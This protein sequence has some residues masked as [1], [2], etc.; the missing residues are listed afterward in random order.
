MN[1]DLKESFESG[2]ARSCKQSNLLSKAFHSFFRITSNLIEM[3]SVYFNTSL[4]GYYQDELGSSNCFDFF[5][6][7]KVASGEVPLTHKAF[8]LKQFHF[9]PK[10]LIESSEVSW[11]ILV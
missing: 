7:R 9:N 1:L 4:D 2:R 5:F 11:V 10:C 3:I 6:Y 8:T